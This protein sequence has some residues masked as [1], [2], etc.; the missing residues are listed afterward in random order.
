MFLRWSIVVL[1]AA[2]VPASGAERATPAA[3]TTARHSVG[4]TVAALGDRG[5]WGLIVGVAVLGLTLR[6]RRTGP[7]VTS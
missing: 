3:A 5:G 7:V 1:I 4:W 2:A 6:R